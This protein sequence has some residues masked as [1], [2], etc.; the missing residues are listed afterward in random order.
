MPPT[1]TLTRPWRAAPL[2]RALHEGERGGYTMTTTRLDSVLVRQRRNMLAD[3]A[4][5]LV[6]AVG[7]AVGAIGLAT[8]PS[9]V[10][11]EERPQLA[12]ASGENDAA[13]SA[14]DYTR[15]QLRLHGSRTAVR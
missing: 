2:A 11:A 12:A 6:A 14:A 1:R 13:L 10:S 5:A 8:Q 3:V 9:V 7:I 15:K 4:L